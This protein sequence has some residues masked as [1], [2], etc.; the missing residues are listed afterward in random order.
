MRHPAGGS[1]ILQRRAFLATLL[2]SAAASYWRPVA[3]RAATPAPALAVVEV[4]PGV[5]VH[6][7]L[8]E[9]QSPGNRGDIANAGFIVGRD[10]VAVIDTLGSFKVGQEFQAAIRSVTDKPIRYVINTHMHPDH[11]LGNAAFKA[12]GTAFVG[13]H[14][15]ERGLAMRAE[16]YLGTNRTLL[17]DEAFEGTEIVL[18]TLAVHDRTTIDL[19]GRILVCEAQRTAHTDNDL[20]VTDM[21]T[22]TLFMGDLLFSVQ[23]PTIDGS[24]RG[25][26]QLLDEIAARK[27][28]RVVP[29]HGPH[30]MAF[31][32]A[33]APLKRYL[34]TVADD[35]RQLILDNK[36]LSD[37][38]K[39]A[40]FSE[41]ANWE[42]FESYHVR[43]VTT[44]F[45]ELEW[46]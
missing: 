21:E 31:P 43:N 34:S 1:L 41:R 30:A 29:G 36:T 6:Q 13:H 14:K 32:E 44:A 12:D 45:A 18:P 23:V 4:A 10:A 2:A 11:V 37:A 7:G 15:L 26:L 28:Q 3:A 17:G 38:T 8:Y 27:A 39:T 20:I 5:F 24:I 35:V 22:D 9:E 19:G 46:E 25:W 16:S 33:L 40:G 42:L